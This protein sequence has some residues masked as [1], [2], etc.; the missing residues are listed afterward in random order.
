MNI[1][2]EKIFKKM[3][4]L[5]NEIIINDLDNFIIISEKPLYKKEEQPS[6]ID[7]KLLLKSYFMLD[8]QF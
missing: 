1:T 2:I 5:S 7:L 4:E 8:F 3:S 6:I